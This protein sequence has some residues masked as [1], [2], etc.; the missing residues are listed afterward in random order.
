MATY[1]LWFFIV[2]PVSAFYRFFLYF[3][4]AYMWQFSLPLW[5]PIASLIECCIYLLSRPKI[6]RM[7]S[8]GQYGYPLYFIACTFSAHFLAAWAAQQIFY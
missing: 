2:A 8:E 5:I 7:L 3:P 1:L 4:I 6:V